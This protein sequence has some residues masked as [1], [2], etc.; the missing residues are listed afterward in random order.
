MNPLNPIPASESKSK[1][2]QM[3]ELSI[4]IETYQADRAC[5]KI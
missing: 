5:Q 1:G 3:K 4:D 2:V